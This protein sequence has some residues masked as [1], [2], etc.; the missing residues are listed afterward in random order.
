[1][2]LPLACSVLPIS[3][4]AAAAQRT[5]LSL[6]EV[7]DIVHHRRAWRRG[8]RRSWCR[9]RRRFPGPRLLPAASSPGSG[10]A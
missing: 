7:V 2:R 10:A 5:G 1:M 6:A 9:R 4:R 3:A 8:P